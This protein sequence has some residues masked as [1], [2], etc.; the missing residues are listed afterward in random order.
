MTKVTTLESIKV[1]LVDPGR[2]TATDTHQ[3]TQLSLLEIKRLARDFLVACWVREHCPA[4]SFGG[5]EYSDD[6]M[7]LA[8]A[9]TRDR[10]I[11]V[12]DCIETDD[13]WNV[14][15]HSVAALSGH[16]EVAVP[17]RFMDITTTV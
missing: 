3:G 12:G 11:Q 2:V 7:R 4:P 6:N 1:R 8:A 5:D 14:L 17:V 9:A 10:E 15:L 13:Q 16:D